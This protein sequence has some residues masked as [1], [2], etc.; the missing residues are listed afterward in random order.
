MDFGDAIR[1]HVE[2]KLRLRMLLDGQGEPMSRDVVARDDAC[3][4]GRWIH[5]QGRVYLED[6]AYAEL[7]EA[8]ARFHQAAAEIVRLAEGGDQQRAVASLETGEYS[9]RSAAVVAAIMRM[10]QVAA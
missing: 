10:R 8:H 1:A 5:G 2:W 4:L 3:E 6:P 9:K 7:K